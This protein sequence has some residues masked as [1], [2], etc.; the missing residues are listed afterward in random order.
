MPMTGFIYPYFFCVAGPAACGACPI[1]VIERG[2]AGVEFGWLFLLYF[3]GYF[4][5]ITVLSGR[6]FCGWAC[7][8]GFMSEMVYSVRQ[9]LDEYLNT[10]WT[11]T[12]YGH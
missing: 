10:V 2:F 11:M 12:Q 9:A 8:I 1:G 3:I 4:G 7:P 6:A 5:L